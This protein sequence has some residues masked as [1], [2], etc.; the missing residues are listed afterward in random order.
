M[1]PDSKVSADSVYR[2]ES[3]FEDGGLD[4]FIRQ[5][6]Q[7]TSPTPPPDALPPSEEPEPD[8]PDEDDISAI[9]PGQP[10]LAGIGEGQ[11]ILRAAFAPRGQGAPVA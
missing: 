1:T 6:K 10:T 8:Q 5:L 7:D 9:F 3:R 11:A 4:D 2:G